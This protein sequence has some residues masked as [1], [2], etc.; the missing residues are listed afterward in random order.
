MNVKDKILKYIVIIGTFL[1]CI[2]L[3]NLL[4]I[5]ENIIPISISICHFI[6]AILAFTGFIIIFANIKNKENNRINILAYGYFL[7]SFLVLIDTYIYL[8]SIYMSN[9]GSNYFKSRLLIQVLECCFIYSALNIVNERQNI[10]IWIVLSLVIVLIGLG[11]VVKKTQEFNNHT[12]IYKVISTLLVCFLLFTKYRYKK[13]H[14][15]E[16]ES[17]KIDTAI[18]MKCICLL[19]IISYNKQSNSIL[20][21]IFYVIDTLHYIYVYRLIYQVTKS[22]CWFPV[23]QQLNHRK[24]ELEKEELEKNNLVFASYALKRYV[25]IIVHEA[26]ILKK[27]M[28]KD[29]E[30]KS[31]LHLEKIKKN[32][33][34]LLKLS[35]NI[36][37]LG[38]MHMG[39]VTHRYKV[40]NM[41]QLIELLVESIS[42][43]IESRGIQIEIK[44][45]AKP[46]Y[47]Y[48]DTDEMERVL[49]NLISNAIKYSKANGKINIY[50]NEKQGR[51]YVCVEDTGVGIPEEKIKSIF[52]RFKRVETGFSR[53]QEGSGL[54][55]AIVKTIIDA[56]Q[57][58]INISSKENEGT[59]VSFNLP[60][61]QG[62]KN[63]PLDI[64]SKIVLK[65]KIEVE[66]ADL[67]R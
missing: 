2:F 6:D 19:G 66:F 38:Q 53:T 33:M 4:L 17:E 32:C 12:T 37:D 36:L 42:P 40:T 23:D 5:K 47:C 41:N 44:Q 50:I 21:L 26:D 56:H 57:G 3:N 61:Y 52:E 22:K 39:T 8:E 54:G 20:L 65:R 59:L 27:K 25:N 14:V 48:V 49:L 29:C 43:Y 46:I 35:N 60:I 13:H 45:F 55:L 67:K 63:K 58:V 64:R 1:G 15:F 7:A 31:I 62:H 28:E 9:L 11:I 10:K 24:S 16:D 34:R 51:A 30:I 18:N